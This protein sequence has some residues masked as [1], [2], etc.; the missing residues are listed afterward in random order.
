M[1]GYPLGVAS[2]QGFPTEEPRTN[3]MLSSYSPIQSQVDAT[4][5]EDTPSMR[6]LVQAIGTHM[7]TIDL[8]VT[9]NLNAPK[10]E[11]AQQ[12]P[13]EDVL[14]Q[15]ADDAAHFFPADPAT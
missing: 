2:A 13:A 11:E 12:L 1:V 6:E 5:D 10:N 14:D 7:K 3:P 15:H 8:E 9:S 4:D